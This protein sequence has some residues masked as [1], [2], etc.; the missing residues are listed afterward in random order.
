MGGGCRGFKSLSS[1]N[2]YINFLIKMKTYTVTY[3]Q[4]HWEELIERV[5]GGETIGVENDRGN[6]A[7][8]TPADDDLVRIY[9][10]HDE[11]S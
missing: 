10:E 7:V 11:A 6:R 8:M 9:C 4:D 3:W 2:K 1:D 5:E